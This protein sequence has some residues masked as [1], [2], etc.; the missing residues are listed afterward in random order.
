MYIIS[1]TAD[2]VEYRLKRTALSPQ[3][4]SCHAER[5]NQIFLVSD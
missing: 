4:P 1:R 5:A 2:T 3:K